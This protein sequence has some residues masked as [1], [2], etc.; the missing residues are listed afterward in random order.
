M[1]VERAGRDGAGVR[2]LGDELGT[3]HGLALPV[4]GGGQRDLDALGDGT[5]IGVGVGRVESNVVRGVAGTVD[6]PLV[7]ADLI[8]PG[9]ILQ[10][11]DSHVIEAARPLG[12]TRGNKADEVGSESSKSG[13]LD[14]FDGVDELVQ[15]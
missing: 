5:I 10:G 3:A 13:L 7:L 12:G 4:G 1:V 15:R 11:G 14:H 6:V 9:P 8:G 2:G